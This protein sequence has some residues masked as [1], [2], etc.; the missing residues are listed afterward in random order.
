MHITV[1]YLCN[2]VLQFTTANR[3]DQF[4]F[5]L[6]PLAANHTLVNSSNVY[7]FLNLQGHDFGKVSRA[8]KLNTKLVDPYYKDYSNPSEVEFF[9][10]LNSK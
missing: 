1:I 2:I 7:E 4:N 10:T 8:K 5:F 9:N 6:N 3:I